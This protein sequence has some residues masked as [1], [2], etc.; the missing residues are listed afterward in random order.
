MDGHE[1][2][3]LRSRLCYEVV[4]PPRYSFNQWNPSILTA[5]KNSQQ[6]R[7]SEKA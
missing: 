4:P 6:Q 7:N 5:G 3:F 1:G 2:K